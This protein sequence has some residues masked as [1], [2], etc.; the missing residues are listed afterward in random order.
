MFL[1]DMCS[2]IFFDF[3][4]VVI[5]YYGNL[6]SIFFGVLRYFINCFRFWN[7]SYF[8][9]LREGWDVLCIV[10]NILFKIL[11]KMMLIY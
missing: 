11:E 10:F 7:L 6:K 2:Y 4:I 9:I 1:K 5:V 3:I 8:L